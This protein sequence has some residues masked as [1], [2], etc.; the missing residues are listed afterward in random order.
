VRRGFAAPHTQTVNPFSAWPN[1]AYHDE[2]APVDQQERAAIIIESVM[3]LVAEGEGFVIFT[4]ASYPENFV[5]LTSD[6]LIEVTSRN[7]RSSKLP[8]LTEA[9][10]DQL[11]VLGLSREAG[12]N[13]QGEVDLS[14]PSMIAELCEQSFAILGSAPGFVIEAE[15]GV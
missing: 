11:V 1:H 14:Q 13:H 6:G 3:Q 5:Q 12:P 2:E 9:Q 15:A 4:D 10:V 7:Y 8:K